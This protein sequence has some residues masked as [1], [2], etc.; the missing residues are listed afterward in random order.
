M[1]LNKFTITT[2]IRSILLDNPEIVSMVG[3]KIFPL[4]APADTP[5]DYIVYQRDGFKQS[6]TKMGVYRQIPTVYIYII[7]DDYD[8]SQELASLVYN[9]LNG[10]FSNPTM[11]ISLEDSTEEFVDGKYIQ[12]LLFSID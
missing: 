2:V 9:S 3:T 7:S 1:G 4:A 11:T 5:G 12:I 10:R 8:R 6:E